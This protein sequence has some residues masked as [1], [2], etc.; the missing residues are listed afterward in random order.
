MENVYFCQFSNMLSNNIYLPYSIG[1]IVS[2]LRS[3][4]EIRSRYNI[5]ML[6]LKEDIEDI[7][8][9]VEDP[10]Y[11]FVSVYMWNFKYSMG[12]AKYIKQKYPNCK[13]ILGGHHV[14]YFD[15]DFFN[16]FSYIDILVHGEGELVCEDILLNQ[17]GLGYINNISINTSGGIIRT[18]K[19]YNNCDL[20]QIP[21]PYLT[22][23]FDE[24]LDEGYNFTGSLE[25]NRGC[26]YGCFYC[27]W[28]S[29]LTSEKKL[30]QFDIERVRKEIEWFGKNKIGFIFGT[31]S[32]FGYFDRDMEII[33]KLIETKKEYGYPEKFRVCYTKNS[34]DKVF[35]INRKLNEYGLS[36]GATLSFQSLS[37]EAMKAVNRINMSLDKFQELV[38]K[39]NELQIPT[40]TEMILGLPEETYKSFADGLCT[41]LNRGQHSSIVVYYCQVYPNSII[42]MPQYRKKH[43]METV[44]IP[45]Y[46]THTSIEGLKNIDEEEIIVKTRTMSKEQWIDT[47]MFSWTIQ[48][49]HCL[50]LTQLIARYLHDTE[51][52]SYKDFYTKII[53]YAKENPK[54]CIGYEY[55]IVKNKYEEVLKGKGFEYI[56]KQFCNLNWTFEEGSFL[57][58]I[59]DISRFYIEIFRIFKDDFKEIL[60]WDL[61]QINDLLL[62]NMRSDPPIINISSNKIKILKHFG[63]TILEEDIYQKSHIRFNS[64]EEYA[65]ETVWYGR[66]GGS[67]LDLNPELSRFE[68]SC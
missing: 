58:Y 65:I 10:K 7:D 36:K 22:G 50:G 26:P 46:P 49:F 44:T 61:T 15:E 34:D 54:S 30:R 29:N 45:M 12:V 21:S 48:T 51:N 37:F 2:Y 40:Y 62:K 38:N 14:P 35:E 66:K 28:G 42:N 11:F 6:Y 20:N 18:K 41:L 39:Y 16:S 67:M 19:N 27:D 9:K 4:I 1:V 52:Y 33:D 23:V 68:W 13:I 63:I 53:E 31:D 32:N 24:M 55:N 60:I 59:T 47:C 25:T 64:K 17:M 5:R 3:N 8:K 43:E 57:K 56:V